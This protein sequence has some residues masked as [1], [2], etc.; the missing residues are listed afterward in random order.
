MNNLHLIYIIFTLFNLIQ[1]NHGQIKVNKGNIQIP[2]KTKKNKK[3]IKLY[4]FI[5]DF[6]PNLMKLSK[7]LLVWILLIQ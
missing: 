4:I 1:L 5:K 6:Y 3:I 2:S 7:L